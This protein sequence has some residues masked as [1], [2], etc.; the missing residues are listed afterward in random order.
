MRRRGFTL[1]ELLVVI[2]IIAILAA[3]LFPVF[4]KAREKARQTACLSNVKQI[5]L[6]I[7]MYCQDYDETFPCYVMYPC[8]DTGSHW[9]AKLQP[10]VKNEQ[11]FRCPTAGIDAGTPFRCAGYGVNYRHV[12]P[13]HP[14][15]PS[16]CG[17]KALGK[18]QRP[19]DTIMVG[20]GQYDGTECTG[21]GACPALYCT[22][23]W[24]VTGPC[25]GTKV[26][27]ALGYRHNGGGNFN[28]V[29]G[30]AKWYMPRQIKGQ[31]GQGNEMWGHYDSP[32]G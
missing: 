16:E 22:E 27:N 18:M 6:S 32:P 17:K 23:C 5:G 3:I 29:D 20:D 30:H 13:C 8:V 2:A 19:A 12:I 26:M 1:I 15:P 21:A 9:P 24:P 7:L 31:Q 11:I 10:Y 28:F 25:P 14:A 4:A